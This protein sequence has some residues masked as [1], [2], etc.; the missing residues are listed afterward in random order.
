MKKQ[1]YCTKVVETLHIRKVWSIK[2]SKF[3][4]EIILLKKQLIS[5]VRINISFL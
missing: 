3:K 5:F 4:V 1:N 2:L